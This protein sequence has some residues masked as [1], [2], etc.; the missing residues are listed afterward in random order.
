[1]GI[2]VGNYFEHYPAMAINTP[3]CLMP[4]RYRLIGQYWNGS[5]TVIGIK[6][7]M[8]LMLVVVIFLIADLNY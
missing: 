5:G 1:M 2:F 8:L 6:F 3:Q 4:S 7:S